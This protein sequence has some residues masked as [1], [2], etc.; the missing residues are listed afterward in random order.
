MRAIRTGLVVVLGVVAAAG[1]GKKGGDGK[2]VQELA[3]KLDEC[4]VDLSKT[5]VLN[6]TCQKDL[7]S[8]QG[9]VDTSTVTV[10][11]VGDVLTLEARKSSGGHTTPPEYTSEE[12]QVVYAA[13]IRVI[14]DNRGA[15]QACYDRALKQDNSLANQTIKATLDFT[16]SSKG[17]ISKASVQPKIGKSFNDCVITNMK[18]WRFTGLPNKSM[19]VSAPVTLTS[20]DK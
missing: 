11:V 19:N 5:K 1:C 6:D 10:K 4:T 18:G 7:V 17:E 9:S 15:I 12:A 16:V 3:T 2:K 13:A 20:Q 14:R 8:A